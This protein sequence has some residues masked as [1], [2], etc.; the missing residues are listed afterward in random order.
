MVP[1]RCDSRAKNYGVSLLGSA[2]TWYAVQYLPG[3][4]DAID[5]GDEETARTYRDLLID[6]LRA[7]ARLAET[8][9]G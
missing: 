8:G 9:A 3:M 6:S 2:T 7:A 1:C 4:R 5:Q